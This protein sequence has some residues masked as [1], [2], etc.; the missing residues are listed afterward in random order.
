[1]KENHNH[2]PQYPSGIDG[3]KKKLQ[4]FT[5]L[6]FVYYSFLHSTYENWSNQNMYTIERFMF[7][8]TLIPGGVETRK[9]RKTMKI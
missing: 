9:F 6:S 4:I 2:I 7:A 8:I 1:M 5:K 3:W